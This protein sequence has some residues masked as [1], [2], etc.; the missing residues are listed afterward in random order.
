MNKPWKM[1]L[2]LA[3]IFIAGGITGSFITLRLGHQWMARHAGPEQW[4]PNHLKRLVERLDLKP[5]QTE[6]IHPIVHRNMEEVNHLRNESMTE[7]RRIIERMEREISDKLTP[8]QRAKFEQMNREFRERTRRF[9]PDRQN[10]QSGPGG[11]RPERE[12][13]AGGPDGSPGTPPP[14]KPPG[15]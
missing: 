1:I 11:P 4:A 10:R 6:Q 9:M 5:E 12:R 15:G 2:M 8:E 14:D 3:G 7:T 13:P